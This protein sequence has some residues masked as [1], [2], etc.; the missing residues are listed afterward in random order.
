[1]MERAPDRPWAPERTRT[2]VRG[3]LL[4]RLAPGEDP[5]HVP[6]YLQVAGRRSAPAIRVDGGGFDRTVRRHSTAMMVTR[7][8]TPARL[9]GDRDAWDD[10]EVQTGMSRT[11]RLDVDP[12][13]SLLALMHE[14][15]GLAT[16]ESVR[17]HYLSVTPFAEAAL[18]RPTDRL[19][20]HRMVGVE[21][22]LRFEPGDST[23][24]VAVV[25]SGV[26]MDHP[27]L[28]SRLRPGIDTVDLPPEQVTRGMQLVG[29]INQPDRIPRDEMGHGTA[30]ASII[31]AL[32]D[33]V[34]RGAAGHARILPARALAAARLSERSSM[35]A[36]GALP[37]IDQAVKTAVDLGARVLNLSFGT[38]QSALREDDALPHEEVVRYALRRGCI[39]VAASGNDGGRH[40]YFPAAHEG[41]IAV[42]SVDERGAPSMFTTR[43]DHVDLCGPGEQVPTAGLG[44]YETNT[45]TS[46]AAPFVAGACALLVARGARYGVPLG[47]EQVRAVLRVTAR[48]FAPGIDSDGCGRGVLDIPA[49][50]RRLEYALSVGD[51]VAGHGLAPTL[52]PPS[53]GHHEPLFASPRLEEQRR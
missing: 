38:P 10:V 22:A 18:R 48:P 4:V 3:R 34:P 14:L 7:A 31:G 13:T 21:E 35:T 43:G 26:D 36:V 33:R 42:G 32:G 52:E 45:G 16:V 37:D 11:F 41:V 30:C 47:A 15:S 19:Y 53:R 39:L 51:R 20:A 9:V 17:P 2:A 46:F 1:M 29:D 50:L 8:F 28:Q 40:R 44:G 12:D 49:A 24:I 23:L 5:G 27:E 6:H 25:D